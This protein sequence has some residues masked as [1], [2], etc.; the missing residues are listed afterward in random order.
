M[1]KHRHK[2]LQIL[3]HIPDLVTLSIYLSVLLSVHVYGIIVYAMFA[4]K[5]KGS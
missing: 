3:E 5:Y 2:P 4:K 1:H